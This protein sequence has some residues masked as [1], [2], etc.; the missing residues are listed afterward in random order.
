MDRDLDRWYRKNGTRTRPQPRHL[1]TSAAFRSRFSHVSAEDLGE[2]LACLR[3]R[4]V[5]TG[6]LGDGVL[7]LPDDHGEEHAFHFR[8]FANKYDTLV[9]AT[10]QWNRKGYGAQRS[11][12]VS[13]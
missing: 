9:F 10:Y 11:Q 2:K 1:I 13:A 4:A 8:A 7:Y 5:V 6:P 3:E 12:R